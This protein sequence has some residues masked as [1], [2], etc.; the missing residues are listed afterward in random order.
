MKNTAKIDLVLIK[1]KKI[2]L[3]PS[4]KIARLSGKL[5]RAAILKKKGPPPSYFLKRKDA[6]HIF[7]IIWPH[8][9]N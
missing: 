5:Y 1:K 3:R 7:F 4:L 8:P 9:R 2:C 6:K